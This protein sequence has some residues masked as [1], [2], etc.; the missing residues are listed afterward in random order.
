VSDFFTNTYFSLATNLLE[1]LN[2]AVTYLDIFLLTGVA[3]LIMGISL[4]EGYMR[5]IR[6]SLLVVATLLSFSASVFAIPEILATS[7]TI[8]KPDY[9]STYSVG[10]SVYVDGYGVDITNVNFSHQSIYSGTLGSWQ[11]SGAEYGFWA[12]A[13]ISQ[14]T[15]PIDGTLTIT[16]TGANGDVSANKYFNFKP[17]AE[18]AFPV[19]SVF[20]EATGYRIQSNNILN[21]D[22]YNLWLW[23]PV[24][25][26]YPSSQTVT[27]IANFSTIPFSGLVDGRTYNLYLMANNSFSDGSVEYDNGLFRSYTL[28]QLTYSAT[29]VPEPSTMLLLGAGVAGLAFW[30]RKK[31]V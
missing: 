29:P 16:A 11:K 25:R 10:V 6:I 23:D 13:R 17:E 24:A 15:G 27:D 20:A 12:P 14:D 8:D 5:F 3:A 31:T 4:G 21:A 18:L 26:F 7:V 2:H 9:S 22:Y 1:A 28:E 30:R 19:M